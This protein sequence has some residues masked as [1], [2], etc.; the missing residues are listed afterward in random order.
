MRLANYFAKLDLEKDPATKLSYVRY[1][2]KSGQ[3]EKAEKFGMELV[4]IGNG[5]DA[6]PFVSIA[7]RK[8][9]DSR[10][11]WLEGDHDFAQPFDIP[12]MQ[13]ELPALSEKL[14]EMHKYEVHPFA[15][16][17]RGGTQTDGALFSKQV[18]EIQSLV[19]H[20][21]RT[22]RTYLDNLP[23]YDERHPLLGMNRDAFRFT[24]SWSV[25][26]TGSG[27]HVNHIHN[28]GNLSSAFY[29]TVPEQIGSGEG[30]S[31]EGWLA[32]GEP[33]AELNTDFRQSRLLSQSLGDWCCFPQQ[34]GMEHGHLAR[35]NACPVLLM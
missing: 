24:G 4:E 5:A 33:A 34:C 25:R 28:Q 32:V 13:E 17:L 19:S 35:A 21:R 2:T 30:D 18:P 15:Q 9:D 11:N 6:W 20:L 7:W 3:F 22:V 27:F 12:E 14:R 29:V 31:Q 8:L 23:A 10:W 16:S 1:L 26:L